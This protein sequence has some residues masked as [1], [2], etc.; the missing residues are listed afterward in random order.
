[1]NETHDQIELRSEK[2]R[3]IIGQIPPI[4]IR[5]GISIIFCVVLI[6][7]ICS[8]FF[9]YEY[10]I[11]STGLI[12]EKKDVLLIDIKIPANEIDKIKIGQLVILSFN[13]IPNLY[14]EKIFT[15]IQVIPNK[16]E[17]PDSGGFYSSII[18]LPKGTRTESG[19]EL[20]ILQQTSINSEIITDKVSFFDR[21]TKSIKSIVTGK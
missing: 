7:L 16:I 20:H 19:K 8:W 17:V 14:N 4:I 9:K 11:K 3:N 6:L 10:T 12:S 21:L 1:M 5:T 13:E 18:T 15:E 2:V